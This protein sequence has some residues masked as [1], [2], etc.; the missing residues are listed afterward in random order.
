MFML[1]KHAYSSSAQSL[2]FDLV[3]ASRIINSFSLFLVTPTASRPPYVTTNDSSNP[4]HVWLP[5][6]TTMVSSDVS[7]LVNKS[8][9]RVPTKH[10]STMPF[11]VYLYRSTLSSPGAAGARRAALNA[12]L[13][14]LNTRGREIEGRFGIR[15]WIVV[16]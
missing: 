10:I 12:V 16:L 5:S 7:F 13:H 2:R 8:L 4:S 14:S 1:F 11:T 6:I 9:K 15:N 3:R